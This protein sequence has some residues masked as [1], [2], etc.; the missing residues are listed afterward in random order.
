MGFTA[1]SSSFTPQRCKKYDSTSERN[2]PIFKSSH[3][4][5]VEFPIFGSGQGSGN[6]PSIW[7]FI[8]STLCD[9][10]QQISHGAKFVSPDGEEE[11][12]ITM[13]GEIRRSIL[14]KRY[15]VCM[16]QTRR[17]TAD[18]GIYW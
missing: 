8:S 5:H 13:V 16:H 10:H 2:T 11:V 1:R 14:G 9:I 3:S 6:S 18:G 15:I 7:L 12:K 4:H 17:L